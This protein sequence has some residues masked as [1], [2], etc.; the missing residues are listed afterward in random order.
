MIAEPELQEHLDEIRQEVCSRCV[1]RP[2]G[3]PPCGPLGKP[4]G[5]ELH[6]PQLVESVRQVHSDLI[7]P[8]LAANRKEV[9]EYCPYLH[10]ADYCP[11]PMDSLAV[12][13]VE[14]IEE[15][16]RRRQRRGH[17]QEVI[18]TLPGHARPDMAEVTRAYEAAAGTWAGCDWP[19]AFGPTALDLQGWAT[20]EAEAR[21]VEAPAAE[22][23]TWEAAARWLREV[24]RRAE[25]AESEAELAVRAADAG[26]WAQAAEHAWVAWSI[27]FSTGRP[28]RQAAPAWQQLY[29]ALAAAART[30]NERE[31]RDL[32]QV[33]IRLP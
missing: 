18:A 10:H 25:E 5:V 11:C 4:C 17:G 21:A 3:G 19:T 31:A 30:R 1:E 26:D 20:A 28:F 33:S 15:V 32:I 12:L 27:E 9:C 13:V 2:Y 29:R 24:E 16:E 8:Y 22:R 14:A 23:K 6:L 7:S